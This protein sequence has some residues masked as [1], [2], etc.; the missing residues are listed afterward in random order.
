MQC[1]S[2]AEP[3]GNHLT[4]VLLIQV[5]RDAIEHRLVDGGLMAGLDDQKLHKALVAM[6]E[7]PARNWTLDSLAATAGMSRARFAAHFSRCVGAPPGEYLASWRIGLACTLLR[8]GVPVKQVAAELGYANASAL[9]RAFTQRVG[10][11][12]VT[13]VARHGEPLHRA[14]LRTYP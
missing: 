9:G 8:R 11:P 2:D 7:A 3:S 6:H 10:A 14:A 4:E 5:L 1:D 13:W 12:P